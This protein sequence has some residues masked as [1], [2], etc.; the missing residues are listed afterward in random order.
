MNLDNSWFR[1]FDVMNRLIRY[2]E[3]EISRHLQC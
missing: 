2:V 3:L 1:F